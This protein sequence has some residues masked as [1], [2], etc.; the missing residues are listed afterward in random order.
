MQSSSANYTNTS[1]KNQ[2]FA[3]FYQ[4][5]A[6]LI[7]YK[8]GGIRTINASDKDAKVYRMKIKRLRIVYSQNFQTGVRNIHKLISNGL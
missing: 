1:H 2:V 5:Q 3:S 8:T 6:L 4:T 7:S